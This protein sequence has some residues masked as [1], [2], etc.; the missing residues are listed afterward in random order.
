MNHEQELIWEYLINNALG[1]NNAKH[2]DEIANEIGVPPQG[3]NNDNIRAWIKDMVR[4]HGRQI[5]TCHEGA[6]IILTDGER[7]D[8]AQFLE[9]NTTANAVRTNGN[10]TPS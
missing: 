6:F 4:N 1:R 2:I 5:G 7:E 8:A 10:Y 9:R 3:T